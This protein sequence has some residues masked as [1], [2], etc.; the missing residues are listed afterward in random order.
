MQSG[1]QVPFGARMSLLV[2]ASPQRRP[3]SQ[4]FEE[5]SSGHLMRRA[6]TACTLYWGMS[7]SHSLLSASLMAVLDQSETKWTTAALHTCP[8]PNGLRR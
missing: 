3:P 4:P 5:T 1:V 7:R 2:S 6:G 8:R